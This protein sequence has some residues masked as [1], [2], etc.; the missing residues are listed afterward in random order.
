[1]KNKKVRKLKDKI[2]LVPGGGR[3]IGQAI[4]FAF[5][6][7]G[8]DQVK[9]G[10]MLSISRVEVEDMGLFQA[11]VIAQSFHGKKL[12]DIGQVYE[13]Q[14][15]IVVNKETARRIGYPISESVLKIADTV[16]ETIEHGE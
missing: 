1:M 12:G 14:K 8:P 4:A 3:G 5:A 11:G 13:E 6:Q 2:A 16:Y 10:V 15:R 9:R 7:E